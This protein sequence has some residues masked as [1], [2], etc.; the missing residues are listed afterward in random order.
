MAA[1]K[2]AHHFFLFWIIITGATACDYFN[3]SDC[4]DNPP[5]EYHY[6]DSFAYSKIPFGDH[7]TLWFTK[8]RGDTIQYIGLGTKKS[9]ETYS[10]IG[11]CV[12]KIDHN[13]IHEMPFQSITG[14]EAPLRIILNNRYGVEATQF[15]VEFKYLD[16]NCMAINLGLSP[17]IDSMTI[18]GKNYQKINKLFTHDYDDP[19][20]YLLYSV[21]D[22]ILRVN[23]GNETWERIEP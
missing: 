1:L 6:V 3:K 19:N 2:Y 16:F 10:H 11:N 22:G 23:L 8:N 20:Y 12:D 7:D 9:F 18:Q 5:N 13:E 4:S 15:H 17:E 21:Q 14:N